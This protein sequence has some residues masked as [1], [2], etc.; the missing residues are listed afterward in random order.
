MI[1]SLKQ[2]G[3]SFTTSDAVLRRNR[4]SS[5]QSSLTLPSFPS[6]KPQHRS[7]VSVHKPLH[8][9]HSTAQSYSTTASVKPPRRNSIRCEAYEADR[10]S[11][12]EASK[13]SESA[14]K[15]KIGIY[16]AT[17]WALNVVFNIYN[18]KVLN[19][20][21]YPWLTSTLSLACGSLMMLISWATRIVEAPKTDFEF[22]KTL[23][24][25]GSNELW[26]LFVS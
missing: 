13:P 19:A 23:F 12:I 15:V 8:L 18:K 5:F 21:P 20:Y 1:S 26:V 16:F 10:S 9:S 11:E 2:P 4:S 22:W 24:P 25:V 6:E 14:K 3:I 7:L 17:W